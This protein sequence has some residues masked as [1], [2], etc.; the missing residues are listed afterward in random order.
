MNNKPLAKYEGLE[1]ILKRLA[2]PVTGTLGWF[3]SWL[4][5]KIMTYA[6]RKAMQQG[7]YL[8]DVGETIIT[9]TM[10][11]AT[12]LKVTKDSWTKVESGVTPA[13]GKEIDN[14]FIGAF[15]K[16]AVF[17]KVLNK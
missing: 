5:N 12:F 7:V 2:L 4:A 15:S 16:F 3:G 11:E 10:D 6:F 14:A 17:S 1:K 9:T 13:Q 8:I